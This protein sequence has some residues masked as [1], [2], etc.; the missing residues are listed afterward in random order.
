MHFLSGFLSFLPFCGLGYIRG[1]RDLLGQ[2]ALGFFWEE[3]GERTPKAL[4]RP[5]RFCLSI[6]LSFAFWFLYWLLYLL[7]ITVHLVVFLC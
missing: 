6:S 2:P 4:S 3:W 5:F 1:L 7:I